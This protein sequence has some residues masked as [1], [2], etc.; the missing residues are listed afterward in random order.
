[1]T[2]VLILILHDLG[3]RCFSVIKAPIY[4]YCYYFKDLHYVPCISVFSYSD[5]LSLSI[6]C[7]CAVCIHVKARGCWDSQREPFAE[8]TAVSLPTGVSGTELSLCRSSKLFKP[9]SPS[10]RFQFIY[11]FQPQ[12]FKTEMSTSTWRPLTALQELFE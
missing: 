8:Q 1:M 3:K 4:L 12:E 7:V 5:P 10:P 6:F 2:R 9:L 11:T